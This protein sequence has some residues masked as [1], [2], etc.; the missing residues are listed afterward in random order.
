MLATTDQVVEIR[1]FF[2]PRVEEIC[3]VLPHWLGAALLKSG[4]ARRL[5]GLATGGKQLPTNHISVFLL[6][7][8][9]AGLRRFRRGTYMHQCET[10][11]INNW[12]EAV[13][14]RKYSSELALVLAQAGA[15]IKG[16]GATRER[17]YNQVEQMLAR[18]ADLAPQSAPEHIRALTEAALADDSNAAFQRLLESAA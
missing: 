2:K 12:S 15:L 1:D 6:L 4:A 13:L 14:D 8:G 18:A 16:Y 9:L 11:R 3:G 17:G 10:S 5:I 7:R